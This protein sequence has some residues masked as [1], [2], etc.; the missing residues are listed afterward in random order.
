MRELDRLSEASCE[1]LLRRHDLG[2]IAISTP[3]GPLVT[4]VGYAV[5]DL[6][7][8]PAVAI[9]ATPHS[10]LASQASP[11]T[12]T[13][14]VDELDLEQR[15]GWTVC[16]RGLCELVTDARQR[17]AVEAAWA[18]PAW[19]GTRRSVVLLLRWHE[20]IGHRLGSDWDAAASDL[21]IHPR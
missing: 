17:A 4:P 15:E 19:P 16:A 1:T 5:V 12:V 8:G 2:H 18:L 11:T 3:K 20:L 9:R 10:V 21:V 13:L 6:A 7:A 14:E